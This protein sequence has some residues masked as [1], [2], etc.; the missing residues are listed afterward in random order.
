MKNRP[1]AHPVLSV[2]NSDRFCEF[3]LKKPTLGN[4]DMVQENTILKWYTR[5]SSSLHN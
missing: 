4:D 1:K 3:L 5:T 2:I